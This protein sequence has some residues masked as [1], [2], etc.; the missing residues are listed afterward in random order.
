[1][2]KERIAWLEAAN[3]D[4]CRE[5]HEYRSKFNASE[6]FE[7][8]SQVCARHHFFESHLGQFCFT[9]LLFMN[10]N[11][12]SFVLLYNCVDKLILN[13]CHIGYG[14]NF[15]LDNVHNTSKNVLFQDSSTCSVK[16]EG[17]KRG[18]QSVE[19]ADYQMGETIT[20]MTLLWFMTCFTTL[21]SL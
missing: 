21:L 11:L 3:E 14:I 20:G 13:G 10:F 19:S 9:Q 5:L 4:L 18:L 7:R 1:M 6:H 15:Q 16:S 2:L 12:D 17:L 8:D